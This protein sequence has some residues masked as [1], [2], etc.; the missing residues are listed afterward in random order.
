VVPSHLMDKGIFNFA[1][2][3]ASGVADAEGDIAFDEDP[4][5]E[6][7]SEQVLFT[8]RPHQDEIAAGQA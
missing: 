1:G 7:G 4:C 2:L 6:S 5:G 3:V 8:L